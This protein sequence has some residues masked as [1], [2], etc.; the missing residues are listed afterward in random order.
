VH[1]EYA[2]LANV[3]VAGEGAA[4]HICRTLPAA[5]YLATESLLPGAIVRAPAGRRLSC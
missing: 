5:L 4:F 3:I 1:S 2:L